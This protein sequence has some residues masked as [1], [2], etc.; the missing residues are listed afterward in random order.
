[1]CFW[2][3][4]KGDYLSKRNSNPGKVFH[5]VEEFDRCLL[6]LHAIMYFKLHFSLTA[7]HRFLKPKWSV[8]V[9]V[10]T[11]IITFINTHSLNFCFKPSNQYLYQIM[12]YNQ[13][14]L[15]TSAS[16]QCIPRPG[17][18]FW[19]AFCPHCQSNEPD[20]HYDPLTVVFHHLLCS[21]FIFALAF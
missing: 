12:F 10:T 15:K 9:I 17:E 6:Y 21:E 1:M 8:Q 3:M 14:D 7:I 16:R 4:I 18:D 19:K 20:F 5:T 13:L 2:F 11:F